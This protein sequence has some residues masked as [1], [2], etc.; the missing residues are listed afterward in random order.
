MS[1]KKVT[2]IKKVTL[3]DLKPK[4]YKLYLDVPNNPDVECWVEIVSDQSKEYTIALSELFK[5]R[6]GVSDGTVSVEDAMLENGKLYSSVL[7]N[8]GPV[9]FFGEAFSKEVAQE[10][11]SDYDYKWI[12][13]Q[14]EEAIGER[15][16]FFAK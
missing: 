9:E 13:M 10:I 4:P 6:G 15:N 3:A 16:N 5:E 14:I 2:N 1:A 8:W 12:R 7:M 11:L